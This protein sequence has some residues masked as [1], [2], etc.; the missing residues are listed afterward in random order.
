MGGRSKRISEFE[1]SLVYSMR[2]R[3]ARATQRKKPGLEKKKNKTTNK[4][5]H[6]GLK[7]DLGTPVM[8]QGM[9]YALQRGRTTHTVITRHQRLDLLTRSKSWRF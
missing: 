2:S 1:A 9:Y 7:I 6:S 3:T 4:T 5:K 8:K